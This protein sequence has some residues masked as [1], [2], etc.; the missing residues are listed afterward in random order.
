MDMRLK[1][2]S[3][4]T[5]GI[6]GKLTSMDESCVVATTLEHAFTYGDGIKAAMAPGVYTCK[7]RLSPHFGY[8][9][10]QIMNVPNRT[11]I[12]IH[13]GN[14]N[15]D[16]EGCVLLGSARVGDMVARSKEA[17]DAFMRLQAGLNT[18]TLVVE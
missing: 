3:F 7:R 6:F 12:E 2:D 10:F 14:Y 18:F 17:F 15:R 9:L 8:E 4:E 13:R 1:R 5:A 11:F 16:S